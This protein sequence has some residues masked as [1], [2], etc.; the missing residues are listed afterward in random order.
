[1]KILAVNTPF[2]KAVHVQLIL[3]KVRRS[4]TPSDYI[5]IKNDFEFTT[6]S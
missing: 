6:R 2:V 5:N 4:N 3:M 1:M